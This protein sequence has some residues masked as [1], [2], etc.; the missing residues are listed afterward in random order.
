MWAESS[1]KKSRGGEKQ[2][3]IALCGACGGMGLE[4][5]GAARSRQVIGGLW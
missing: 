1:E 2:L 5:E 4:V 3:S